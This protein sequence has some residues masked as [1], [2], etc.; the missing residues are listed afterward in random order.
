MHW[1]LLVRKGRI[2]AVIVKIPPPQ[3]NK[4]DGQPRHHDRDLLQVRV[5]KRAVEL[6]HSAGAEKEDGE[7]EMPVAD[8]S[9]VD[10][11]EEEEVFAV[12]CIYSQLLCVGM[13][14]WWQIY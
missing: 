9:A 3:Q 12:L 1:G 2:V 6:K 14:W 10:M 11:I 13:M 8:H 4:R 5:A 7:Q